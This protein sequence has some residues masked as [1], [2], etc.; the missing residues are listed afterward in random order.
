MSLPRH[1]LAI[2]LEGPSE[3]C[4]IAGNALGWTNCTPA[5]IAMGISKSTGHAHNPD[6]CTLRRMTGDTTGGT[7]LSQ[8]Q[9]VA[10]AFGVAIE[11]RSGGLACTPTYAAGQLYLGRGFALQGDAGQL[12]GTPHRST[13]GR[14]NHCVWVNQGRGWH[15]DGRGFLIP[16]EVLVYD[17]AADGKA[18]TWGRR[19]LGPQWWTWA[20]LLAFASHLHVYGEGDERILGPGA[21][22]AALFP[23]TEPH[24]H[25]H[26]TGSVRTDP[27]PRRLVI[28]PPTTGKRV[29]VRRGPSR[30]YEVRDTLTVGATFTAYQVNRSGQL[31]DGSRVWY[32]DH[33]GTRW[34]HASGVR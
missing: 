21:F 5:S 6:D 32:G 26:F 1:P 11:V 18:S 9:S 19:A 20:L 23:R 22:Y 15:K 13:A 8:Y 4:M 33:Y 34:V 2:V 28:H 25:L 16:S 30:A 31:L 3:S 17:P 14:V 7:R 24:V 27:F 10:A 29:N 12:V